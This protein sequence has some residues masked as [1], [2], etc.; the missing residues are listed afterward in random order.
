MQADWTGVAQYGVVPWIAIAVTVGAVLYPIGRI[1]RRM[2]LSPFLSI[3]VFFPFVNLLALWIVA[4]IEWPK[5]TGTA[6]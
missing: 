2:G 1:L 6:T 4:F 3:V 5:R